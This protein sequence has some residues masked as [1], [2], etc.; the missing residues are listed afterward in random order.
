MKTTIFSL[1]GILLF[2]A[3]NYNSVEP[4]SIEEINAKHSKLM[5]INGDMKLTNAEG[6]LIGKAPVAY[7]L[8]QGYRHDS[9]SMVINSLTK[10]GRAVNFL[11]GDGFFL[12]DRDFLK[13]SS[14]IEVARTI[15]RI[16]SKDYGTGN[17]YE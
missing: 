10:E 7:V 12:I 11:A 13:S 16:T 3:F 2:I 14:V 4:V 15:N 17:S 9:R 8:Y 1:I 6:E 5:Q